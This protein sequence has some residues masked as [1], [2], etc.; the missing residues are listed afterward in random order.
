M[1]SMSTSPM[2]YMEAFSLPTQFHE[3]FGKNNDITLTALHQLGDHIRSLH[4]LHKG[5]WHESLAYILDD[6]FDVELPGKRFANI[7]DLEKWVSNFDIYENKYT[8]ESI[9]NGE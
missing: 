7:H 1:V 9:A 3:E 2:S 4:K 8:P 6:Q 5:A